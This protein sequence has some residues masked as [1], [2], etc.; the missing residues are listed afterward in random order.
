[1]SRE[2][3][4][5]TPVVVVV[6]ELSEGTVTVPVK[7]GLLDVAFVSELL[8]TADEVVVIAVLNPSSLD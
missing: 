5:V 1:M 3:W 8:T 7:V 4:S 6:T 2:D